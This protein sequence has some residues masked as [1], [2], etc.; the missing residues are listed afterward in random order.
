MHIWDLTGTG[1][2]TTVDVSYNRLLKNTDCTFCGQCVTHCPTG[3]L[4]VRDETN[5]ALRALADPN[6]VTVV[7]VAPAVRV[8]WA[9]DF[10]LSSKFATAGRMG[11][12][13]CR[14]YGGFNLFAALESCSD[15]L[16]GFGGHEL[17]AGFTI[18]ESNIGAFRARMNRYVRSSVGGGLPVSS[19]DIDAALACPGEI[20]LEEVES[21]SMNIISLQ[22]GYIMTNCYLVCD[23]QTKVCAV[24]DPG[25]DADRIAAAVEEAGCRPGAVL[26]THGH[27]DH[28][29]GVKDL[30][31][32]YPGL[33][34]YLNSRD[35]YPE[36]DRHD[37]H[38]PYPAL[39]R[40]PAL[41]SQCRRVRP[42]VPG[43]LP[44][45]HAGASGPGPQSGRSAEHPSAGGRVHVDGRID[46]LSYEEPTAPRGSLLHRLFG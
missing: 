26:L 1:S 43:C 22:V 12:G 23:E 41:R 18:R 9:E 32:R 36:E 46:T 42:P 45:L 28:T 2:R 4:T 29:G 13:S 34:V 21:L 5:R 24:V 19:L 33:P 8:A 31:T 27:Y 30:L 44:N 25:E 20:S 16:D 35:V 11:K 14:S 3:A 39:R 7:Q 10:G 37:D 17:A 40:G 15:L 38:R 6:I